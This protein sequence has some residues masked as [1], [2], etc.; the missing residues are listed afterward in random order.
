MTKFIC[1]VL[2]ADFGSL[3]DTQVVLA[4]KAWRSRGEQVMVSIVYQDWST[5]R[6]LKRSYCS[7]VSSIAS[8][9]T[10]SFED[11]DTIGRPPGG[12]LMMEQSQMEP[13]RQAVS[14]AVQSL[15]LSPRLLEA[16]RGS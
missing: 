12:A 16:P 11:I 3:R 14:T 9:D 1:H 10:R 2:V 5:Q 6:E 4:L 15:R 7:K 13:Q 8:R